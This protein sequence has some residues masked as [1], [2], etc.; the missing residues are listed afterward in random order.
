VKMVWEDI[1]RVG[2]ILNVLEKFEFITYQENIDIYVGL[3]RGR[4][5]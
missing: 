1:H 4:D 3:I 5:Q 2:D